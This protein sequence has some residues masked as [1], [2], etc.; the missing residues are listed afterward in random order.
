MLAAAVLLL[1]AATALSI[2]SGTPAARAP[3]AR[4]ELNCTVATDQQF[5]G[6]TV[7]RANGTSAAT[8]WIG[9]FVAGQPDHA[10]PLKLATLS[11]WP[12]ANGA[13]RGTFQ[14][15]NWRNHLEF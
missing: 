9:L 11:D 13:S 1:E 10:D 6:V 2:G 8:D 7:W 15:L 5:V 4:I 3:T 14:I 12:A